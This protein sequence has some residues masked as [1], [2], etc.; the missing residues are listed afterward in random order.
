[1]IYWLAG[2]IALIGV[3][4]FRASLPGVQVVSTVAGVVG[5]RAGAA[6]A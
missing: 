6:N 3:G 4:V 1:M 2:A 5:L